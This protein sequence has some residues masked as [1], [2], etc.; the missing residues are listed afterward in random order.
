[1]AEQEDVAVAVPGA[2]LQKSIVKV[3]IKLAQ[4]SAKEAEAL[5]AKLVAK[6]GDSMPYLVEGH[7]YYPYFR[8][9]YEALTKEGVSNELA[10]AAAGK[11]KDN[12]VSEMVLEGERN[13]E[14]RQ[15][16]RKEQLADAEKESK[17]NRTDPFPRMYSLELDPGVAIQR[18]VFD[19]MSTTAQY[20]AKYGEAFLAEAKVRHHTNTWFKFLREDDPH[21]RVFLQ[22]VDT[23]RR[24]LQATPSSVEQRLSPYEE[25]GEELDDLLRQKR[26]FLKA[27]AARKRAILL[28]DD[29]LKK[30]LTWSRFTVVASYTS[31]D[32]GF[33]QEVDEEGPSS[34]ALN[35]YAEEEEDAGVEGVSRDREVSYLST[36]GEVVR[37]SDLGRKAGGLGEA[38]TMIKR[39]SAA[40]K[41]NPTGW[42]A[43]E[44]L[45]ANLRRAY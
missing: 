11:S 6:K 31:A 33:N 2:D 14:L 38:E 25:G 18:P 27:E 8:S 4:K 32:L 44:Q 29:E 28:T 35:G 17:G 13:E 36:T 43:D 1:M 42:G 20:T 45:E 23:Y 40:T 15:Q 24:I 22:L 30:R 26:D 39:D 41:G 19:C 34:S 12:E 16:A 21:H 5:I 10:A 7:T 37:G 9:Q 3:A